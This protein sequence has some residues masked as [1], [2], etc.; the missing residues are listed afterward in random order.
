MSTPYT[1]ALSLT[2]E[3]V[4]HAQETRTLKQKARTIIQEFFLSG[5]IGEVVRS[6]Q[7]LGAPD[8]LATFLKILVTLA[9]DRYV[10]RSLYILY[11]N[12]AHSNPLLMCIFPSC[13]TEHSRK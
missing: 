10:A 11:N 8:F 13:E 2:P 12:E 4:G 3:V 6:L 9:M 1:R 7:D 5:D